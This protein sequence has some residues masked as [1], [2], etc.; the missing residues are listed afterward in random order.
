MY[1]Y[2]SFIFCFVSSV[3]RRVRYKRAAQTNTTR[4]P[5]NLYMGNVCLYINAT[6]AKSWPMHFQRGNEDRVVCEL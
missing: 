4:M 5:S 6:H 1:P 3:S 2:R